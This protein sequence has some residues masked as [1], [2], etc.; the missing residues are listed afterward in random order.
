MRP[1]QACME[2]FAAQPS[3]TCAARRTAHPD[4]HERELLRLP[5]DVSL[6]RIERDQRHVRHPGAALDLYRC[7]DDDHHR[8]DAHVVRARQSQRLHGLDLFQRH[9]HRIR[10]HHTAVEAQAF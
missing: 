5:L 9:A 6:Q 2:V 4:L 8:N 1:V 10:R 7:A 3:R